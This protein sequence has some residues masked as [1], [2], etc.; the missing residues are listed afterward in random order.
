MKLIPLTYGQF[1]QV[2][3]E[4]HDYISQWKWYAKKQNNRENYYATRNVYKDGK[5]KRLYMHRVI[6]GTIQGEVCDHIDHNTLNNQK[7][8][9][10]NC[11]TS[12]NLCNRKSRMGSKSKYIGVNFVQNKYWNSTIWFKGKRYYLGYFK[13]EEEAA[14]ARDEKAKELHGEFVILNFKD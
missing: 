13:T 1:A 3:D 9:L 6:A 5:T 14:K 7:E 12:E 4:D 2:D 11:K 8:N 10:R